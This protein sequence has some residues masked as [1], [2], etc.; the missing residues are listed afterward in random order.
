MSLSR[1]FKDVA[2]D[3]NHFDDVHWLPIDDKIITKFHRKHKILPC[4]YPH[5]E[6]LKGR[7]VKP[8]PGQH[9]DKSNETN[10]KRKI[11]VA[12]DSELINIRKQMQQIERK[13]TISY[14]FVAKNERK[15]SKRNEKR[16]E[17]RAAIRAETEGLAEVKQNIASMV[18]QYNTLSGTDLNAA[19]TIPAPSQSIASRTRQRSKN[20][21]PEQDPSPKIQYTIRKSDRIIKPKRRIDF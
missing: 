2:F 1:F 17:K 19:L 12:D 14:K 6:L 15:Q 18:D 8:L 5:K 13:K 11:N 4:A 16:R 3:K 7:R 9:A 21:S 20:V 10:R